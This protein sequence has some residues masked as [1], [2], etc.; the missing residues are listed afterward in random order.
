M[1]GL[2]HNLP[3]LG[4]ADLQKLAVILSKALFALE[5]D[6]VEIL[7]RCLVVD[8]NFGNEAIVQM[9]GCHQRILFQMAPL[10]ILFHFLLHFLEL[11][12]EFLGYIFLVYCG[13]IYNLTIILNS[14]TA[15]KERVYHQVLQDHFR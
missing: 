1:V 15:R 13:L 7:Q 11:L 9:L 4:F 5:I 3:N 14:I 6:I 8:L 2:N 10:R 12:C